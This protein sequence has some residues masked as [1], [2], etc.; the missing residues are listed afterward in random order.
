MVYFIFILILSIVGIGETGYLIKKRM[1][2]ER[3]VCVLNQECHKVLES[4]YNNIFGV[5]NDILGLVF[6]ITVS[7]FIILLMAEAGPRLFL[8]DLV[9]VFILSGVLFSMILV[10]IQWRLIKSWCFWCLLSAA[11]IIFMAIIILLKP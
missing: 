5:K 4:K 3:P 6:Y 1:A 8:I 11:T 2:R 7:L 10:F 9:K